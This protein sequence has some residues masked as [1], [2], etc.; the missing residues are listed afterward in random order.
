MSLEIEYNRPY[1]I[2]EPEI[3]QKYHYKICFL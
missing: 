2:Y 3:L 1:Q